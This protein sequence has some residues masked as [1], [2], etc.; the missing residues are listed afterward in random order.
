MKRYRVVTAGPG[1]KG[2]SCVVHVRRFG[3]LVGVGASFESL[4]VAA[5]QA[6]RETR[7]RRRAG[8]FRD[9]L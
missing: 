8:L 6:V 3:V 5:R 7:L 4:D 2:G 1:H 9:S